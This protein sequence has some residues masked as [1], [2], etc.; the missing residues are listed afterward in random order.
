MK[1]SKSET[2]SIQVPG[3]SEAARI[4]FAGMGRRASPSLLHASSRSF[5]DP[6]KTAFSPP[7][8]QGRALPAEAPSNNSSLY[9]EMT[10]KC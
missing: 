9:G 5:Y 2:K 6:S 1:L 10:V 3:P 8:L 4:S 7:P